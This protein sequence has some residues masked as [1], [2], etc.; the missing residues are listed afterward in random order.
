MQREHIYEQPPSAC[1]AYSEFDPSSN[2][3]TEISVPVPSETRFSA[4][5]SNGLAPV[6]SKI[7]QNTMYCDPGYLAS[8]DI[9]LVKDDECNQL[10]VLV[11]MNRFKSMFGE[12]YE[13]Q[14]NDTDH[15]L[16]I[17]CEIKSINKILMNGVSNSF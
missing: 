8:K 1:S 16:E 4:T 5:P 6:P 10:Q 17:G 13:S 7:N 11:P 9:T 12:Q 3:K 2:P 14:P 15:M